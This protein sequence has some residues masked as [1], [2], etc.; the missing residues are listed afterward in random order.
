MA[1]PSPMI[2]SRAASAESPTFCS[3]IGR[4]HHLP[5]PEPRLLRHLPQLVCVSAFAAPS[6]HHRP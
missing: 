3:C 2:V 1:L 6:A 5:E 4:L